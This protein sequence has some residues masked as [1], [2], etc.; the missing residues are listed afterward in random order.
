[1]QSHT[2][3]M[4]CLKLAVIESDMLALEAQIVSNTVVF[5]FVTTCDFVFRSQHSLIVFQA[6]AG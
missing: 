6:K 2:S 3:T 1:M 4:L 5:Q